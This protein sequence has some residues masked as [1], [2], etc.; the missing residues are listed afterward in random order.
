MGG[1]NID[2][3]KRRKRV[4]KASLTKLS[5]KLTEL[6]ADTSDPDALR[7]AQNLASKLKAIDVKFKTLPLAITDF[8]LPKLEV[9]TFNGDLLKWK[10]FW[11]QFSI[12]IHNRTDLTTNAEKIVYLQNTLNDHTAKH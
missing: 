8:N 4:T 5:S 2:F 3:H 10:L 1:Y 9:P 6:E 12:S 7:L 11:D